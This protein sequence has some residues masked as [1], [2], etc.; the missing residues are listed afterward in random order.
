MVLS[1]YPSGLIRHVEQPGR[2]IMTFVYSHTVRFAETDAAGVVYFANLLTICHAG[3]E[4]SLAAA[5]V[6]LQTFF[7]GESVA[8]PIVHAE[9]DYFQPLHCGDVCA[10]EVMPTQLGSHKFQV[11]Y[12]LFQNAPDEKH[13][14]AAQATTLHLCIHPTTR[15]KLA[16]PASIQAWLDMI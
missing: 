5:G 9:A 2:I 1:Q 6:D 8:M 3:Y 15:S 13:Q 11:H 7:R 14:L 10:I 4:A 16:L 12:R